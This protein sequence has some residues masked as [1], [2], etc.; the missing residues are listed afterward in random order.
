MRQSICVHLKSMIKHPEVNVRGNNGCEGEGNANL[1]EVGVLNLIALLAENADTGNVCGCSDRSA[2]AAQGCARK[3]TEVEKSR[4]DL[5]R[6]RKTRNNGEHCCN[7]GDVIDERGD[8]HR[9]PY[10]NGVEN[11]YVSAAK[12]CKAARKHIDNAHVSDT[13]DH[14]EEAEE[15]AD[16][17]KVDRLERLYSSLDVLIL[18]AGVDKAYDEETC[19][20]KTV[21]D[22]RFV[23]NKGCADKS[24]DAEAEKNGRNVIVNLCHLIILFHKTL[25]LTEEEVEN[26]R[27]CNC[28]KLNREEDTGLALIP[29]EIEEAHICVRAEHDSGGVANQ[30]CRALK[31]RGNGNADDKR[32]GICLELFAYLKSNGSNHKNGGHVINEGG[33]DSREKR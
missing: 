1:E 20:D 26:C 31:V 4:I 5:K 10:Y 25:F 8:K 13:A 22:V 19:A 15:K 33:D 11:K 16:G 28:A 2:V 24:Y 14:K 7:V 9:C 27:G 21:R 17:L 12:L 23:G 18:D 29:E 30:C 32:N 3:E 6:R